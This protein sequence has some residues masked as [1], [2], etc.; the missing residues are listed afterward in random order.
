MTA[1][2]LAVEQVLKAGGGGTVGKVDVSAIGGG[3]GVRT[4]FRKRL[5]GPLN[6]RRQ[7]NDIGAVLIKKGHVRI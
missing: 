2:T 6:L 1:S 4:R 3:G 5:T 7:R